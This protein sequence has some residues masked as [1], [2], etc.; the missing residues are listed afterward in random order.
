MKILFCG[1]I[2]PGGVLHYQD[3]FMSREIEEY[4]EQFELRVGTFECSIGSN[5]PF[6]KKKMDRPDGKNIVYALD[7][8]IDKIQQL[9]IDVVTLA[10]NHIYDQGEDGLKNTIKELDKLEIKHCG[11]GM[12]LEEAKKPAVVEIEGKSLA[13]IGCTFVNT[14]PTVVEAATANTAGIYQTTIN[15]LIETIRKC[16]L[17]YDYLFVLPHWGC[18]FEYF[19]LSYNNHW[20]Q[21]L[22]DNGVDGIIGSHPHQI[23]PHYRYKAKPVYFSLGNFLF[24]DICMQVP[25]PMFYPKS[26][27]E[28]DNLKKVWAYPNNLKEP[29]LAIWPGRSRIGMVAEIEIKKDGIIK[30]HSRLT[31]MSANNVLGLYTCFNSYVKTLRLYIISRLVQSKH[32]DFYYRLYYTQKNIIRRFVHKASDW[33]HINYDVRVSLD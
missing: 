29:V 9:R 17:K 21:K 13:F 22:I 2:M 12:T 28:F 26:R 20:S 4:L 19:P 16:K 5:I 27:E 1:D 15:E 6:D 25:R 3:T 31:C 10:N 24:P 14:Y 33:L 11:A 32:Y 8:D 30:D 7:G 23:Q 18:E